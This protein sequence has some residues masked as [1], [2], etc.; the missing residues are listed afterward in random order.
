MFG[1]AQPGQSTRVLMHQIA[2]REQSRSFAEDVRRGLSSD[3]KV[4]P[5]KYF[6][7]DLGSRLF[8][9][10]CCLPEYYLTK[11]E[12]EI[13]RNYSGAITAELVANSHQPFRLI[14][15]GSG[16]AEKTCFLIE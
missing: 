9:A 10:I 14:E 6:Y 4:L 1:K 16:N 15:L 7:D 12:S 2:P 5:S 13:L 11:A 8:E 3:P